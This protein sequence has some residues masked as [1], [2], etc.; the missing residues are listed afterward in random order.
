MMQISCR[1][2]MAVHIL[3]C[4]NYFSSRMTSQDLAGSTGTNPVVV[5]KLMCQMKKAGLIDVAC[6]TGGVTL[7]RPAESISLLDIYQA[8]EVVEE[9][10]L[11]HFHEKPE[12]H[13][14]VGGN[15]ETVLQPHLCQAQT[16]MEQ[17]LG[18]VNL[19]Q[20]T[21]EL[22]DTIQIHLKRSE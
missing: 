3:V 5:R 22:I 2:S 18:E 21:E 11:F 7:H 8:V 1:F 19:Q 14:P 4:V 10:S 9:E 12:P 17:K 15:I 20:I 13:C 6:G 16:A